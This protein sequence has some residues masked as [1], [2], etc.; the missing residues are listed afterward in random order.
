M[1]TSVREVEYG[2]MSEWH[3]EGSVDRLA[4]VVVDMTVNG[5]NKFA[6]RVKAIRIAKLL[7]EITVAVLPRR[8]DITNLRSVRRV[9]RGNQY[10][11]YPVKI[12]S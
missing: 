8:C 6:G 3:L 1:K 12:E 9:V 5:F 7:F 11:H 4:L 10:W 2:I